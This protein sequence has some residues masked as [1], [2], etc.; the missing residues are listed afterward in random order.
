MR[1]WNEL[2]VVVSALRVRAC[3]LFG[4]TNQLTCVVVIVS[5]DAFVVIVW[6]RAYYLCEKW[7]DLHMNENNVGQVMVV[8]ANCILFHILAVLCKQIVQNIPDFSN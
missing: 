7:V 6:H 3:E 8:G 4:N 1:E 5:A 2:V